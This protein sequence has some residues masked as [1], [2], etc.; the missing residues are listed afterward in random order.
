MINVAINGFGRIGRAAF[1]IA[2]QNKNVRVV[3]INDLGSP[4]NLAYLLQHDSIYGNYAEKV[5][6]EKNLLRAGKVSVP[7]FAEKDPLRLPWKKLKV[8]VVLEC[9]GVFTTT[10]AATPHIKAGARH[11]I[12]SA[13]AKDE[14]TPVFVQGVNT[15]HFNAKLNVHVTSNASCTTNCMAPV[16]EVMTR[17]FGAQK[18]IA[19]TVHSYTATQALVDS[20][21]EKDFRRGRAAA[22][23][24]VPST[25]GAADA[26]TKTVPELAGNFDGVSFRVPTPTVSIA[27]MVFV[28]PKKTTVEAINA[29]FV[30]EAKSKRYK[31]I[32]DV[33]ND[34]VVSSDFIG[35]S[36]TSIVDASLT[37]VVGGDLVQVVSWYD[38]EWGYATKLVE[39]AVDFTKKL[40]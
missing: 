39:Q 1:K 35:S 36:F 30:K 2:A 5:T 31:G 22:L 33:T 26:T 40:K 21:L 28:V 18:A 29:A 32:L 23:N 17:V 8:D 15:H 20:P 34:P 19:T 11:V 12:I 6:A 13:P 4:K 38:N 25:T 9:T 7:V 27:Q 3:A 10:E 16:V 24:I 37:K 14:E